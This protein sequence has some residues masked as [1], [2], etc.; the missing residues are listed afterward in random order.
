MRNIPNGNV[1]F[2]LTSTVGN[3]G[4]CYVEMTVYK[5][6]VAVGVYVDMGLCG[7]L[8]C[9][10]DIIQLC[11]SSGCLCGYGTMWVPALWS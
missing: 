2:T 4:T 6:V 7:C 1:K 10:V 3:S 5:Y 8:L 9:G 11:S